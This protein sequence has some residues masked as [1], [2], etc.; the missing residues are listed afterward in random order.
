LKPENIDAI[1]A[2]FKSLDIPMDEF[3]RQTVGSVDQNTGLRKPN[4]TDVSK[5]TYKD[6]YTT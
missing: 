3:L 1:K 6:M 4:N 5:M 2:K